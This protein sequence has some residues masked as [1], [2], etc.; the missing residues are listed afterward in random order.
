MCGVWGVGVLMGM[1]RVIDG[2]RSTRYHLGDFVLLASTKLMGGLAE[3]SP[4]AG[5]STSSGVSK[6][7]LHTWLLA[8]CSRWTRWTKLSSSLIPCTA[9]PTPTP[10]HKAAKKSTVFVRDASS[11]WSGMRMVIGGS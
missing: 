3:A 11:Q 8:F 5:P 10:T 4:L 6:M 9:T 2:S 1:L 7:D